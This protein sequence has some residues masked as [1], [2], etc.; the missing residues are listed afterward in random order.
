MITF[1]TNTS[2]SGSDRS[3]GH[4]APGVAVAV[5]KDAASAAAK[6][7]APAASESIKGLK[8]MQLELRT[9]TISGLQQATALLS[10][11]YHIQD[12]ITKAEARPQ[13]R[14]VFWARSKAV[15]VGVGVGCWGTGLLEDTEA[16]DPSR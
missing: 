16:F 7:H 15:G 10:D 9:Q 6:Q 3:T 8:C 4:E 13:M 14:V 5:G 2:G 12:F 1:M 11:V